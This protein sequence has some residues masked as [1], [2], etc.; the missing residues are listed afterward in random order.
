L[1]VAIDSCLPIIR[2]TDEV[3]TSKLLE[4]LEQAT[5][6]KTTT[7]SALEAVGVGSLSERKFVLVVGSNLRKLLDNSW[8]VDIQT[9]E[10]GER[11]GS[12]L[13]ASLLDEPTRG[14]GKEDATKEQDKGPCELNS[15]RNAVRARVH[16][17]LGRVVDDSGKEKTDSDGELITTNDSTTDPL[18]CSFG[19]V[20]RNG[21]TDHTNTVSSEESASNEERNIGSDGLQDNTEAEDNVASNKTKTTT[22]EVGRGRGGEGTEESTSGE[23]GHNQGLLTGGDI[24]LA[25][26]VPVASAEGVL[27]ICHSKD[28]TDGSGIITKVIS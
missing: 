28:T 22:K 10:L 13:R 12:V 14:L 5:G 15:D 18:G 11:L 24:Q 4:G 1:L 6:E 19:L 16:A 23:N 25:L 20:K 7:E 3:H 2:L 26:G 17:F 27:P 9:P 8:V 21:G